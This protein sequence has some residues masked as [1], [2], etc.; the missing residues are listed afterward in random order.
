MENQDQVLLL[1]ESMAAVST[2]LNLCVGA[3][4]RS[5]IEQDIKAALQSRGYLECAISWIRAHIGIRG[6]ETAD[7]RASLESRLGQIAGKVLA[8]IATQGGMRLI[9]KEVHKGYRSQ[10]GYGLG[11]RTHWHHQAL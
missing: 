2:I 7:A 5:Q 3:P 10:A 8:T 4:P 6:N 11:G 1:S 9:S